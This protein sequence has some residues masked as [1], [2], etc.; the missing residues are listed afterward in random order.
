MKRRDFIKGA[1]LATIPLITG[2]IT[3]CESVNNSTANE[4]HWTEDFKVMTDA[5]KFEAITIQ[6]YKSAID[7]GIFDNAPNGTKENAILFMGH[8][9]EHL[10]V[11]NQH[12]SEHDSFPQIIVSDFQPDPRLAD[13][14]NFFQVIQLNLQMEFEA[15]QF[16]FSRMSDQ[17]TTRFV[18]KIFADVFPIEVGHVIAYKFSLG[19]KP[20][21]GSGLF[22]GF[23]TGL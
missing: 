2:A 6:T 10:A 22:Q 13:A 12:F 15:S 23:S 5:A 19:Q 7:S 14:Q 20:A 4:G 17:L 21:I 16:Y 9:S 18:R 8:H 3:G 11:F 1:S